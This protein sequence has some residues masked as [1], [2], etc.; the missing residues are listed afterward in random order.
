LSWCCPGQ[1]C[2]DGAL[3]SAHASAAEERLE[4]A[5][6]KCLIEGDAR[7]VDPEVGNQLLDM[8]GTAA[9]VSVFSMGSH[10]GTHMDAP[11]HFVRGVEGMDRMALEAAVGRARVIE[12]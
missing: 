2:L 6:L 1:P 5:A 8:S 12:I 10:T 3:A 9:N 11:I 7:D 4:A